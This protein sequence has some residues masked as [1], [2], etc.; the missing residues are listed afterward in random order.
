MARI[1]RAVIDRDD[2]TCTN[3]GRPGTIDD[4]LTVHKR[5]GGYHDADLAG[6][7]T[8]HR[9]CHGA[10]TAASTAQG[11]AF[12][13]TSAPSE[14]SAGIPL[15]ETYGSL[16][17]KEPGVIVNLPN[18]QS[19]VRRASHRHVRFALKRARCIRRLRRVA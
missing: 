19:G 1:R 17:R 8:L 9:S 16:F 14:Y 7:Q 2:H 6:Y 3:C 5:T 13:E 4:P 11:G 15:T 18:P 12:H 10:S